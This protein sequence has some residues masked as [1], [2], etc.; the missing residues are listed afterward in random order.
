MKALRFP[1][2]LVMIALCIA[3]CSRGD[4]NT[5]TDS[6]ASTGNQFRISDIATHVDGGN[7]VINAIVTNKGDDIHNLAAT[8]QVL[9]NNAVVDTATATLTFPVSDGNKKLEKNQSASLEAVFN[10]ITSHAQYDT[11]RITYTWQEDKTETHASSVATS[12]LETKTFQ[13]DF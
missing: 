7:P 10:V 11:R 1:L 4:K 13:E 5:S 12:E 3:G 2:I 9:K 8:V 6:T